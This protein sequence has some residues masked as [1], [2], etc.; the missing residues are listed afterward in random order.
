MQLFGLRFGRG[1]A[2]RLGRRLALLFVLFLV[3][4]LSSRLCLGMDGLCLI[5]RSL[6]E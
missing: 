3:L 4:R 2:W 1:L 5:C 6:L